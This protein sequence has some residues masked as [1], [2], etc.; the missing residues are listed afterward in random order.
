MRS[1][2]DL[3]L[4]NVG[5]VWLRS[6]LRDNNGWGDLR[7]SSRHFWDSKYEMRQVQIQNLTYASSMH[8][9]KEPSH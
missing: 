5:Y 1:H 6:N 7:F 8:G 2:S 3:S 4:Q 9:L